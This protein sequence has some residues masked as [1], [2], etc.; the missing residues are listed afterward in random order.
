MRPL[1]MIPQKLKAIPL[2]F[3]SHPVSET[4]RSDQALGYHWSSEPR[5]LRGDREES[6]RSNPSD[7]RQRHSD[8]RAWRVGPLAAVRLYIPGGDENRNCVRRNRVR[9]SVPL[10]RLSSRQTLSIK[11]N[12]FPPFT[13]DSRAVNI[14]SFQTVASV[15][16]QRARTSPA[17]VGP[18]A[19]DA[20]VVCSDCFMIV[21]NSLAALRSTGITRLRRYYGASDSCWP[22]SVESALLPAGLPASRVLPSEHS[23]PNHLCALAI[24][25]T[26]NPSAWQAFWTSPLTGRL[27]SHSGRNGF[28]ILR[29]VHSHR[30]ALHPLS[31]G[32]SYFLLKAGVCMP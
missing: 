12:H 26:H 30:V 13:P 17:C 6:Y 23:V 18:E 21:S 19:T 9:R 7:P 11:L 16:A 31:Q 4:G 20:G 5:G 10:K 28:V 22:F 1:Q 8:T 15:Q 3:P 32:R 24:A 14:R 2:P 29:T 25:F 27:V